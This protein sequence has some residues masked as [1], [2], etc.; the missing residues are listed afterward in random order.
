M[1]NERDDDFKYILQ[2]FSRTMIGAKYT[3]GELLSAER[4]PFKLQ[5]I[6]DRLILPY[7]DPDMSVEEH[8]LTITKEDKNYRIFDNLKLK[9]KYY[10]P[11]PEGGFKEYT[12]DIKTF[13]KNRENWGDGCMIQE[14][15]VS[16]LALMGFKL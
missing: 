12:D 4:A 13:L 14:I 3:Y 11:R 6:I 1:M 2:E 16:N 7:A 5:T 15:I 9:I 10:M 8:L